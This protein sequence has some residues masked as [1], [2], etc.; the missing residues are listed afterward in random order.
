M[1]IDSRVK[2]YNYLS[3]FWDDNI[4]TSIRKRNSTVVIYSPWCC[5]IWGV[6]I[7]I[8]SYSCRSCSSNRV[9]YRVLIP[10]VNRNTDTI[11]IVYI[12]CKI[13][14]HTYTRILWLYS[15]WRPLHNYYCCCIRNYFTTLTS[16]LCDYTVVFSSVYCCILWCVTRIIS[17][18]AW[19]C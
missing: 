12:Y 3:T 8:K 5:C 15:K 16:W 11:S 4:T 18:S 6:C 13:S 10:L 14:I 7:C 1:C 17:S 9:T 2:G 19:C